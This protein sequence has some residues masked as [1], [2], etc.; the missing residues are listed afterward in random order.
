MESRQDVYV[1]YTHK[2]A[3]CGFESEPE[4]SRLP[5]LVDARS[6]RHTMVGKNDQ[7]KNCTS[8]TLLP[9][10]PNM[11]VHTLLKGIGYYYYFNLLKGVLSIIKR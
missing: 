7:N 10:H 1:G 5:V 8:Y 6:Q 4:T 2:S 3:G 9:K 11:Y